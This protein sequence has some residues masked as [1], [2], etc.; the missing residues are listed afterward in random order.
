MSF[1][2]QER[3]RKRTG[4]K[5]KERKRGREK[6]EPFITLRRLSARLKLRPV[7]RCDTSHV[8]SQPGLI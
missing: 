1:S 7:K 8:H 3:K 6:V 4:R 5:R 2:A